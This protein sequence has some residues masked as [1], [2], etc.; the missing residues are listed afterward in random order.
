MFV[1]VVVVVVVVTVVVVV[2]VVSF[3]CCRFRLEF[4][5]FFSRLLRNGF[6]HF[7]HFDGS[8]HRLGAGVAAGRGA[9]PVRRLGHGAV[10]VVPR[11]DVH[12]DV[13]SWPQRVRTDLQQ[14]P[15]H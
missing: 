10:H 1:V 11:D 14:L 7:G 13:R 3:C 6:R 2:A 8:R 9:R 15:L 5:N 4:V 12:A